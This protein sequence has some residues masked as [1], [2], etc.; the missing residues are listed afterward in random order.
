M[1]TE[2]KQLLPNAIREALLAGN[3]PSSSNPFATINDL[4]VS[5]GFSNL[6]NFTPTLAQTNFILLST[7]IGYAIVI[8]NGLIQTYLTNY[9]ITGNILTWNDLSLDTS[10]L[11]SIY[12]NI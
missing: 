7:P 3:T 4:S 11:L 9:T 6:E 10:D 2:I 1:A 12:Y 5:T 8:Q